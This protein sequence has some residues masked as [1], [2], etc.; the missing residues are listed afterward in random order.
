M[1]IVRCACAAALAAVFMVGCVGPDEHSRL[2][3]MNQQMKV[4]KQDLEQELYDLRTV[5]QTLETRNRSLEGE[6]ES[7][8]QLIAQ[9]HSENDVL[10]E[11]RRQ[12]LAR[13]E[14]T[15]RNQKLMDLTVAGPALPAELDDALKRF[16]E[17]HPS[18]VVYDPAAGAVKWQ[19]DILFGL[20]SDVVKQSAVSTLGEFTEIIKSPAASDF[21]VIVAGH[22]DN[23]PIKQSATRAAHPTNW[24]LAVHRSISVANV[25]L[26]NGYDPTR[27]GV[28][29]YG[30]HR[31]VTN[32]GSEEG[33]S[34]NRRVEIY[35]VPKG[36]LASTACILSVDGTS[37]MLA[38]ATP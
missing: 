24:H 3:R 8:N 2:K 21:E 37:A 9:L 38:A 12:A 16:A 23:V 15:A 13:L 5:N 1:R 11:A 27:V 33:R 32:N 34:R 20:G 28:L 29:G 18:S 26:G 30:E 6:L 31:P 14:E 4:E 17:E 25:L 22:T 36:A 35:L 7:K 10:D 19:G